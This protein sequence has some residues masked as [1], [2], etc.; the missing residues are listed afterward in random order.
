MS[1]VRIELHG[2]NS[3]LLD[4]LAADSMDS[5]R[6]LLIDKLERG[7]WTFNDGDNLKVIAGDSGYAYFIVETYGEEPDDQ[8]MANAQWLNAYSDSYS[9]WQGNW[10]KIQKRKGVWMR[11][12]D[13]RKPLMWR[14]AAGPKGKLQKLSSYDPNKKRA[15]VR[16]RWED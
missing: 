16:L 9:T 2:Q 10:T 12:P 4:S 14:T 5:L 7:L 6:S 11:C 13:D 1:K 3:G 15:I 8:F